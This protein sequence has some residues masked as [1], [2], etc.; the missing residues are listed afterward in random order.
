MRTILKGKADFKLELNYAREIGLNRNDGI[1]IY[2]VMKNSKI[3]KAYSQGTFK[4]SEAEFKYTHQLFQ[5]LSLEFRILYSGSIPRPVWP[6]EVAVRT[7]MIV[8]P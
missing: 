1:D 5:T 2:G 3:P 6:E 8:L 7:G 4:I